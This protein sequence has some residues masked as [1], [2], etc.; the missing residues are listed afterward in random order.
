LR[1]FVITILII[2][3][4]FVLT[5]CSQPI[6]TLEG[7]NDTTRYSG[8]PSWI[9]PRRILYQIDE[10]FDRF[11][12]FQL[13]VVLDGE[14]LEVDTRDEN[15]KVEIEKDIDLST[16][17]HVSVIGQYYFFTRVGRH[18]VNVSYYEKKGNYSI[19]VFSPNNGNSMGGDGGIGIVWLD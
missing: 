5:N 3:S 11:N 8:L 6:G 9:V 7:G 1:Q 15:I 2:F 17:F 4:V 10:R 14:I 12:D 16:Y 19:E 13:F 18:I